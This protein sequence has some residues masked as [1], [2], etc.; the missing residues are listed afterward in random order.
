MHWT[1][2][3]PILY[4]HCQSLRHR[5]RELLWI[6]LDRYGCPKKFVK[7]IRLFND[8]IMGQGAS[9]WWNISLIYNYEWGET[10]LSPSSCPTQSVLGMHALSSSKR[11]RR[12]SVYQI[13]SWWFLL[14][15]QKTK[16]E[17]L[18]A[19]KNLFN[20]SSMQMTVHYW[21]TMRET[22]RW[23]LKNFHRQLNCSIWP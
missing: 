9:W 13:S 2:Y 3:Y 18:R 5:Q 22:Y 12:G 11:F 17:D 7:I 19:F 8:G 6:I 10:G 23:W 14:W 1:K 15:Y 21:L 16:R 20:Q 4:L